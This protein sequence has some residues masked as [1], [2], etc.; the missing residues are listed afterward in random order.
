MQL[1]LMTLMILFGKIWHYPIAGASGE[2]AVL[3]LLH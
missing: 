2:D 1:E 3:L